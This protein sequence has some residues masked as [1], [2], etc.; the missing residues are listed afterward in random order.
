V[1]ESAC[2]LISADGQVISLVSKT[3]GDGP[4]SL[5]VPP[6]NFLNFIIADMPAIVDRAIVQIGDLEVDTSTA[7]AWEARP[8][9]EVLRRS[10]PKIMAYLPLITSVLCD[11]APSESFARFAVSLADTGLRVEEE[12]LRAAQS[13]IEKLIN[14]L[15][16]GDLILCAEGAAGLTGLGAG[17]TPDG[18]D[19]LLGCVLAAWIKLADTS[20]E[21]FAMRI[22][23]AAAKR[24]T[25]LSRAWLNASAR[26]EC[27]LNW[28][29]MFE[30]MV[31]GI[32]DFIYKSAKRISEQ[33]HTSGASALAGF[34]AIMAEDEF[35]Q[36]LY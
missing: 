31:G 13:A 20:A 35:H 24:T 21:T 16:C 23:N 34:L 5:V 14:G 15:H 17:L 3:L 9:W 32:E 22:S 29:L 2:N 6:I 36:S 27:A 25:P 19:F 28:H 10:L 18:D 4:F 1:F 12:I 11:T 30:S 33:G 7:L 8:S 26:G